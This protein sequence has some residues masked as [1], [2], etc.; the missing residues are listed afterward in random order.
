MTVVVLSKAASVPLLL[1]YLVLMPAT[2]HPG[3]LGW[4]GAAGV[5]GVV[6]M[7][8][9][10]R[11]MAG[12]AMTIVA[13]V[14]AVTT[15]LLPLGAGL[16]SGERPGGLALPAPAV[17]SP[18]SAWSASSPAKA[19]KATAAAAAAAGDRPA[20][21]AGTR[22]GRRVRA[23]LHLPVAGRRRGRWRRRH[24]AGPRRP[25]RGPRLRRPLLRAG[26]RTGARPACRC[27]GCCRGDARHDRQ[28][29]LHH[30]GPARRPEHRRPGRVAV[31]GEH[32]PAGDAHRSRAAAPGRR[33]PG[34]ASPRPP[35][36]SSP[37]DRP[38]AV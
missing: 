31:P 20:A 3:V 4:G 15:A 2:V 11:A 16:L 38:V 30:R 13:P 24:V 29:P 35:W 18:P 7:M 27:D 28:C 6:G 33:S 36:C 37:R 5:F 26:A 34:S 21:R 8:V 17:R 12:G 10:Y 23:V 14:S 1:V 25:P 22:R 19:A 9:F 32:G